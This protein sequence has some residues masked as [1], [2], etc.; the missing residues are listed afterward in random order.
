M[1]SGEKIFDN[2]RGLFEK[3]K[4]SSLSYIIAVARWRCT[5]FFSPSLVARC[6]VETVQVFDFL[7]I[8]LISI[9]FIYFLYILVCFIF[10]L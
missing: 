1:L 2:L 10:L 9:L 4:L 8:F 7:F 5:N 6:K 3:Y